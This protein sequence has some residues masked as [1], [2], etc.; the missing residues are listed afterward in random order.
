MGMVP[1]F[2]R[3]QGQKP[4]QQLPI[5]A[6][7]AL[8]AAGVDQVARRVFLV[9]NN[10]RDQRRASNDPLEQV[11]AEQGVLAD[12]P[13]QAALKSRDIIDPFA[14]INSLVK[15]ILVHIRHRKGVQVEPGVPGKDLRKKGAVGA[16]GFDGYPWL[17]HG[18]TGDDRVPVCGKFSLVK[19]VR[20]CGNQPVRAALGQGSIG[21]QRDHIFD[22]RQDAHI[23]DLGRVGCSTLIEQQAI[24]IREFAALA[25]PAHPDS[26][27]WIPL[28]LTVE[29]IKRLLRIL[30][31][32]LFNALACQCPQWFILRHV[33]CWRIPEICQQGKGQQ[34]IR[35]G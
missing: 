33:L 29:Q 11:M 19:R 9:Q 10:V 30:F 1:L 12:L 13:F 15:Q 16:G 27:R 26:L 3:E 6:D 17:D 34:R 23:P 5:A 22:I 21:I 4:G 25:L 35:I 14:D 24:K 8:Q 18:I 7:P 31:I 32:E 28:A 2:A 20:Q